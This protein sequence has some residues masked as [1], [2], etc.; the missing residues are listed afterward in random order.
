[1]VTENASHQHFG[2]GIINYIKILYAGS[3]LLILFNYDYSCTIGFSVT[4]FAVLSIYL[5]IRL[6]QELL[7]N[8]PA[9]LLYSCFTGYGLGASVMAMFFRL[10]GGVF[11]NSIGISAG[12]TNLMHNIPEFDAR[13]P[14]GNEIFYLLL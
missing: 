4:A 1:M 13:N 5:S 11:A 2:Q 14:G 6:S 9:I 8:K 12:L 7:G 3:M 10:G